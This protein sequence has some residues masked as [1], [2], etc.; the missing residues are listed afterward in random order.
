MTVKTLKLLFMGTP[1]FALPSLE[2]ISGSGHRLAAVI[3]KP[4]RPRGRGGRLGF[5]PVKEWALRHEMPVYQPSRLIEESFMRQLREQAPDLIV[6]VAYGKILTPEILALPPLGCINLHASLLP[7]YRGAAPIQRAVM[8]GA[9]RTG[10]TVIFMTPEMDAG[11]IILQEAE[12]VS[13]GDT[14]GDL[15]DRLAVKGARLLLRAV[16]ELAHGTARPVS[17]DPARV[18]CAPRLSREEERLDWSRAAIALC[19][20]IRGMNPRPGAY[21]IFSGRR[22][23]VWRAAPH[24]AFAGPPAPPGTI[25]GTTAE[26]L[27]VAAGEG[28]L[29]LLEVQPEGKRPM[30]AGS[31]YRGFRPPAGAVFGE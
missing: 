1:S 13:A 19:N 6:T 27:L 22:L 29:E 28:V 3:T 21:T 2:L 30:A 25:L 16:E 11:D 26:G 24:E 17:Q 31:F 5:S 18:S 4:D 10:V 20:Q 9:D 7:A 23:K 12:P 15:H 14:A 8:D